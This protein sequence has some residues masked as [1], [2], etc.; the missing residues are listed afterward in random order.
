MLAG[1]RW[2]WVREYPLRCKGE[3]G[4]GEKLG[5]RNWERGEHLEM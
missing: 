4:W 3:G 1:V 5:R 2:G